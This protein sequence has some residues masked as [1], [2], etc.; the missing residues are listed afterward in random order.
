MS[1]NSNVELETE[2]GTKVP[3]FTPQFGE[4]L[5]IV[6]RDLGGLKKAAIYAGV[7]DETLANWRDGRSEPRFFGL[8]GLAQASQ[9]NFDWLAK[10]EAQGDHSG[11]TSS[12]IDSQLLIEAIQLVEDWLVENDREIAADKKAEVI[13]AIYDIAIEGAADGQPSINQ[14]QVGRILR[15]VA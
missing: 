10:G 6:I 9:R 11:H 4:R 12:E 2:H 13:A 1:K 8:M 7:T 15:L 5:A 3:S 14:R